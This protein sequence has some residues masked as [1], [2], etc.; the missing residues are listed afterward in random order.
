MAITGSNTTV[1]T[2]AARIATGRDGNIANPMKVTVYNVGTGP[3]FW[4]GSD[5]NTSVGIPLAAGAQ[6][7][8]ELTDGD[9]LYAVSTVT[10]TVAP[11]KVSVQ[12]LRS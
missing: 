7:D 10:Q 8:F 6:K 1:T 11:A 12:K 3:V 2:V 9:D 5:V 4:G